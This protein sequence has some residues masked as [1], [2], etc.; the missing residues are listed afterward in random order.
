[1]R[2]FPIS[3]PLGPE[4]QREQREAEALWAQ[5]RGE[6][7]TGSLENASEIS[8]ITEAVRDSLTQRDMQSA[9][10]ATNCFNATHERLMQTIVASR[11]IADTAAFA[12]VRSMPKW[13]SWLHNL[14]MGFGRLGPI[15][16][17][18]VPLMLVGAIFYGRQTAQIESPYL[19]LATMVAD[20]DKQIRLNAEAFDIQG[21]DPKAISAALSPQLGM[22]VRLPEAEKFGAR[23]LGVRKMEYDGVPT[24]EA[25]FQEGGTR[26]AFVQAKAPQRSLRWVTEARIGGRLYLIREVGVYKVIA[27]RAD[28]SVLAV[29]SPLDEVKSL[30]IAERIR[31]SVPGESTT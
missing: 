2:L 7:K 3:N 26:M 31:D 11:P 13:Q 4:E 21:E 22:Q 18:A 12:P 20:Y 5:I 24:V 29:V 28:D 16:Y 19:P 9:L 23:L 15:R 6:Q 25:H 8:E 1:M 30:R 27:W 14:E 17:A 10:E